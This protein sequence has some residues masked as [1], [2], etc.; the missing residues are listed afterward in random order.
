MLLQVSEVLLLLYFRPHIMLAKRPN[1]VVVEAAAILQ[2]QD[3][4]PLD[5]VVNKGEMHIVRGSRRAAM[6][7]SLQGMRGH[8]KHRVLVFGVDLAMASGRA[9]SPGCYARKCTGQQGY[10]GCL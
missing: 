7:A 9:S 6:L 5:V 8:P 1:P 4:E 2:Q 10:A 3:I